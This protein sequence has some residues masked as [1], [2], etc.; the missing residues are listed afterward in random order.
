VPEDRKEVVSK[1]RK[2]YQE[3]S[4]QWC[5]NTTA[6][7]PAAIVDSPDAA[8]KDIIAVWTHGRGYYFAEFGNMLLRVAFPGWHI[9]VTND[10]TVHCFRERRVLSVAFVS[11]FM[12]GRDF[13]PPPVHIPLL[14][15]SGEVYNHYPKSRVDLSFLSTA[16]PADD[17]DRDRKVYMPYFVVHMGSRVE[18]VPFSMRKHEDDIGERPCYVGYINSHCTSASACFWVCAAHAVCGSVTHGAV[19]CVVC[20]T[21]WRDMLYMRLVQLLGKDVVVSRGR[22]GGG[23]PSY[24]SQSVPDTMKDCRLMICAENTPKPGYVTEKMV[25]GF[26]SGAVPIHW[27]GYDAA[28][29]Y[30]NPKAFISVDSFYEGGADSRKAVLRAADAI[31][32]LARNVTALREMRAEPVS[33]DLKALNDQ[34]RWKTNGGV[35]FVDDATKLRDTLLESWPDSAQDPSK[36]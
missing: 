18:D 5:A 17:P 4:Q 33:R 2:L 13:T 16:I 30:F 9:V 6:R 3:G 35:F 20:A 15:F 7:P 36:R 25:N 22:C 28:S 31:A 26:I 10:V 32:A 11:N 21:V 24:K 1:L 8:G 12:A 23:V 27:G 14:F 34:L 19:C 29:K